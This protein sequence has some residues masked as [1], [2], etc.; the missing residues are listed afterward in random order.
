MPR[1]RRCGC[2]SWNRADHTPIAPS[3]ETSSRP[4]ATP[5]RKAAT[6]TNISATDAR[7]FHQPRHARQSWKLRAPG[8]AH[9]PLPIGYLANSRPGYQASTQLPAPSLSS[10]SS[11]A[12]DPP[13]RPVPAARSCMSS[14]PPGPACPPCPACPARPPCPPDPSDPP[15]RPAPLTIFPGHP[16][17]ILQPPFL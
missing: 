5:P 6:T 1:P 12:P 11:G 14:L 7:S 2:G 8:L 4:S 10:L 13:I 16:L 15:D 9:F 3:L 17:P